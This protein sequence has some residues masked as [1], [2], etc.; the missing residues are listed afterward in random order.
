[1]GNKIKIYV[2]TEKEKEEIDKLR[3]EEYLEWYEIAMKLHL[4][5]IA[6]KK[7]LRIPEEY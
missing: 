6:V 1:M 2:L 7:Y 5:T 3:Y 4:P